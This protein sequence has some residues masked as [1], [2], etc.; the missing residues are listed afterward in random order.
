MK[1][2]NPNVPLQQ[3]Y[4][5]IRNSTPHTISHSNSRTNTQ[6]T[7][8][9]DLHGNSYSAPQYN[10]RTIYNTTS[11]TNSNHASY[12]NSQ[13]NTYTTTKPRK[14]LKAPSHTKE[15]NSRNNNF[16][17]EA[18]PIFNLFGLNIYF[19]DV[20]LICVIFFLYNENVDDPSLF[21]ALVLLLLS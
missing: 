16:S 17:G 12:R 18:S 10:S 11:N 8:R 20:L 1:Y 2:I 3:Q 15:N 14:I 13:A 9:S 5:R 4:N 6:A 19:D 7:P 21:F